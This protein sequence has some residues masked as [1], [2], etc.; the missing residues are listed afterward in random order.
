MVGNVA[1]RGGGIYR[2]GCG[3]L[4]VGIVTVSG[5]GE[6]V[7]IVVILFF[8]CLYVCLGGGVDFRVFLLLPFIFIVFML[9]FS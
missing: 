1:N 9:I 4:V 8:V 2:V 6:G 3:S 5:G 7:I